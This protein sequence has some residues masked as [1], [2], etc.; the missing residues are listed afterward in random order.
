MPDQEPDDV[1]LPFLDTYVAA[2]IGRTIAAW[3]IFEHS[4]NELIWTLAGVEPDPGACITSQLTT[5]ARRMDALLALARLNKV[6][7][8]TIGKLNKFRQKANVLA[9]K[10]NR[11]AHD[12]WYYGFD[13]K[14]HYRLQVTAR[15]TLDFSYKPVTEED[16]LK[17]EKEI[18]AL[19]GTFQDLRTA[20]L[21]DYYA[22]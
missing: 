8:S 9:E 22:R 18:E 5:V 17:I 4:I 11:L 2:A 14:G 21:D 20:V 12:P 19:A 7:D 16:I 10:R 13:G 15:S 3:A 6:G 1:L